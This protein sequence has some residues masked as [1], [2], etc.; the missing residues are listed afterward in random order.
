MARRLALLAA[1]LASPSLVLAQTLTITESGNDQDDKINIAECTG[2]KAAGLSFTFTVTT[3][4]TSPK[5]TLVASD[6]ANCPTPDTTNGAHE[7]PLSSTITATVSGGTATGIFPSSGTTP[8][9]SIMGGGIQLGACNSALAAVNFCVFENGVA[10][11]STTTPAAA[12]PLTLDLLT[13]ATPT[14]NDVSP[15]DSSLHVSW[16]AGTTGGIDA[17]TIGAS[18]SYKVIATDTTTGKEHTTDPISSA[19]G[20]VIGG[21]TNGV[22]YD[23]QVVAL[24]TANNESAR[25]NTIQ[26]TPVEVLDFWRNYK[27]DSGREQ[28]GCA[29]GA[30]GLVALLALAPLALRA[31]RRRS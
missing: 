11:T 6:K 8:V 29:S 14:L 18:T 10:R 17:G 31:R 3:T 19:T 15:G 23:V 9:P 1:L 22:T 7:T 28:G 24:S 13:P 12:A 25:S 21:L 4:A 16:A 26:G 27:Q 20:G 30:A 5:F 2:A